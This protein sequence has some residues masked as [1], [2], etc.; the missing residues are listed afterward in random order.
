MHPTLYIQASNHSINQNA[1]LVN[2]TQREQQVLYLIA[3]E[4]SSKEIAQKLFLS[5]E[6]VNSHRKN[7]MVKLGV[8]NTAGL[9]RV[10]FE[11]GML[12]C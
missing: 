12:M 7:M 9:V 6:T 8:K 3:Y 1:N 10:A 2:I 5:F 11:R 4:H